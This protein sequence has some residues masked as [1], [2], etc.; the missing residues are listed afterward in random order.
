MVDETKVR[1]GIARAKSLTP[2]ER[3][4]I[5][6]KAASARW[7]SGEILDEMPS[8]RSE[9]ILPMGD[10]QIECYVL[11]D[12][13]R[14]IHKR[15]MAKALGM[16]SEGGNVFLR[17]MN[18]KG[19]GSVISP[20]LREKIENPINFKP[21]TQDLAHGYEATVLIEICDAIWQAGKEG[22]LSSTQAFL[23]FQ[24]EIIVR[25]C[26]K[27][28]IIAL[29][30]E[31]TGFINDKRKEEY[32]EL[33]RE[34]IRN[35]CREWEKEFPDQLTDIMYRLYRLPRGV[36]KNRHPQFFGRFIRKYIYAPLAN[37]NGAVLELLD[38]KNPV[39]YK[40][41]GRRYKMHQFL[42]DT[43]GLTAFRQ[44][45]WQI[46]GI[47]NAAKTKEG[48]DRAFKTAFPEAGMQM[49]MFDYDDED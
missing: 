37:S 16:K 34:F 28:G 35:E 19:L 7:N 23:A 3:K 17:T 38:E 42:T 14:L 29:I 22:K 31:A 5:A 44:H 26:A 46:I 25:S 18:R 49:D 36:N 39:V 21:I 32:K 6:R 45:L 2:E 47:G 43:V 40:N 41:G 30:D 48:F 27:V 15:G 10:I 33:F 11:K 4:A 20:E 9:G 8:A 1:G 13:R 12:G 24:A